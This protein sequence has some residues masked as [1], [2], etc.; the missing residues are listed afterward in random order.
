M[1]LLYFP[2]QAS[3]SS[4]GGSLTYI[5]KNTSSA[6]TS[7][8]F[9]SD[10]D[11]TYT[12]YIFQ[13]QGIHFNTDAVQFQFQ[14]S[15]DGGTSYGV[16]A[17]SF[18]YYG[19]RAAT[20]SHTFFGNITGTYGLASA[21]TYQTLGW[22]IASDAD[23]SASGWVQLH[24]PSSTTYMKMVDYQ[25]TY[26][27]SA[28]ELVSTYGSMYLNTTSAIDAVNFQPSSGNMDGVISMYGVKNS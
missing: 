7:S 28:N 6:A 14:F 9:T 11:S 3:S 12:S 19:G 8:A 1:S 4:D 20:G 13:I 21:T 17:V 22:S 15:T 24:Q 27:N 18:M 2:S 10:I 25:F 23:V 5:S 26:H 16:E